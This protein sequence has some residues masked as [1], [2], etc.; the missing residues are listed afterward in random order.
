MQD[1]ARVVAYGSGNL[2]YHLTHQPQQVNAL[3]DYLDSAEHCLLGLIGS[4]EC[5]EPLIIISGGGNTTEQV[6]A[7]CHRVAHFLA[8]TVS[9]YLERCERAGLTKRT[10]RSRLPQYLKRLGI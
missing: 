8:Q 1:A 9:E 6:R 3:H 2:R 7:G 5:L 10:E 4:Q